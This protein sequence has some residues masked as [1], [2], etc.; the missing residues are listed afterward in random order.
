MAALFSGLSEA[1]GFVLAGGEAL[2]ARGE[3]DRLT[4]DLNF[5][6]TDAA[7]VDQ[8]VPIFEATVRNAGLAVSEVQVAAGFARLVVTDGDDRTGVDRCWPCSAGQR[9]ATSPTW[10]RLSRVSGWSICANWRSQRTPGFGGQV[11]FEMLLLCGTREGWRAGSSAH[12][13]GWAATR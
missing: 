9:C 7:Q 6:A 2:I 4:R 3:I 12:Q 10:L 13:C 8:V 1:S 5:F 11:F